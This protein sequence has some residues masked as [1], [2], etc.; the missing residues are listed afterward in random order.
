MGK[1]YL[2]FG[3]YI[4]AKYEIAVVTNPVGGMRNMIHSSDV[5]LLNTYVF[6]EI[7]VCQNMADT[8]LNGTT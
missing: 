4:L 6:R 3:V 2:V 1:F 5:E 7:A 8:L